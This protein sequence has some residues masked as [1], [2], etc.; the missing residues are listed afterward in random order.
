MES[1]R[2]LEAQVPARELK[3]DLRGKVGY[4]ILTPTFYDSNGDGIGDIPGVTQ[5]LDY[6][7]NLGIDIIHLTPFFPTH[8]YDIGYDVDDYENIDPR[9]G[10]MESFKRLVGSA[11]ERGIHV[12]IDMVLNHTSI[13]HKWFQESRSSRD[14]PKRDWY[15]WRDAKED[16]S[17]PNNWSA[18]FGGNAWELDEKTGQFFLHTFLPEQPDLNFENPEVKNE[19]IAIMKRWTELGVDG[20][21][22]DSVNFIRKSIGLPN[23]DANPDYVEGISHPNTKVF[24]RHWWY[25]PEMLEDLRELTEAT[26]AFV[27]SE[28]N[29]PEELKEWRKKIYQATASDKHAMINS[30]L[31]GMDWDADK[32]MDHLEEFYS[33]LPDGGIASYQ[34]SCHDVYKRTADRLGHPQA[35]NAGILLYT[36]PGIP[37][38]YYGDEIGMIGQEVPYDITNPFQNVTFYRFG[39]DRTKNPSRLSMPW[40]DSNHAGFTSGSPVLPVPHDY[41]KHNVQAEMADPHSILNQRRN[42]IQ[43]R[44]NSNALQVGNFARI[45]PNN[46]FVG[47]YTLEH[48]RQMC[49]VVINF[50]DRQQRI[51]IDNPNARI[52][53]ASQPGGL[54]PGEAINL[55]NYVLSP[56][57]AIVFSH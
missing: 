57:Q 49:G 33:M 9:Y 46:S 28:S 30:T 35:R 32:V 19:I 24:N 37:W 29:P 3:S 22:L 17:L 8:L 5:K 16:G 54:R 36:L 34:I 14:N 40:D 31:N 18:N 53:I 10:D 23:A 48:E 12:V 1:E 25:Q 27:F 6:L 39:Y 21:R 4:S 41:I 52:V 2:T 51:S 7:Q 47:A 55:R 45:D 43:Y 42:L 15:I 11:H 38:E 20:F 56:D 44:R 13:H 26:G 50:S